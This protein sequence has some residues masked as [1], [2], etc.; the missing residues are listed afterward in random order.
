MQKWRKEE[1]RGYGRD[2]VKLEGGRS[3]WVWIV[4]SS[5]ETWIKAFAGALLRTDQQV[6]ACE[7][8]G[9]VRFDAAAQRPSVV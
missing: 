3:V 1:T 4:R 6:A 9:A 5:I 2:D 8:A 7:V